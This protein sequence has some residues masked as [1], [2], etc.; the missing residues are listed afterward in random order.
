MI[1]QLKKIFPSLIIYDSNFDQSHVG[2]KWYVTDNDEILG[3]DKN[4]ITTKDEVLLSTFLS[5]YTYAGTPLT[6]KEKF[7][8]DILHG[9]KTILENDYLG[10][11]RFIHF[12]FQQNK[13]EPNLF[14]EAIQS[15]FSKP[16]PILWLTN[17]QGILI[18]EQTDVGEE[19][20]AYNEIIDILMSDLYVKIRFFIGP[21]MTTLENAKNFYSKLIEG[22]TTVFTYT[23]KQVISYEEAIPYLFAD[24]VDNSFR[25]KTKNLL[26][27]EVL[28]DPELIHTIETF[29]ACNLNITVTAKELYMH[30]NSLQY[31]ID[32]FIEKTGIDIRQFHQA[33]TVYFVLISTSSNN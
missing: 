7:W 12:S 9:E 31:R 15:I 5:P 29:F 32:K 28:D 10:S 11:Y 14:K 6:I 30:R 3:I 2:Y 19:S 33:A 21:F 1:N 26:L 4:E 18:E 20:I 27:K 13:V 17:H 16:I 8:H 24:Q 23:G 25:H 22:A